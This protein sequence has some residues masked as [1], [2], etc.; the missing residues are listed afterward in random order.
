MVGGDYS[1]WIVI[2]Q[3][4]ELEFVSAKSNKSLVF[5]E[6]MSDLPSWDEGII[7]EYSF[8]DEHIFL[9]SIMDP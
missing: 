1:K 6:H 5:V 8:M 7:H 9:I 2:F 3:A 4:L